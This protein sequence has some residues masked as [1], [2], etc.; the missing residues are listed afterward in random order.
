MLV[1]AHARTHAISLIRP[2]RTLRQCFCTQ[3]VRLNH[4]QRLRVRLI[5]YIYSGGWQLLHVRSFQARIRIFVQQQRGQLFVVS[6]HQCV[7][8]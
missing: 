3:R 1:R 5:H 4:K 8:L 2:L 6:F 7:G